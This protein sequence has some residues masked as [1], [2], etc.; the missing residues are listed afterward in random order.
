[1][2]SLVRSLTLLAL[3]TVSLFS[4]AC[5]VA[6]P[7][8]GS[9]YLTGTEKPSTLPWNQPQKWE[10]QGALGGLNN[11]SGGGGGGVFGNR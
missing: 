7:N 11:L 6:P 1:M 2:K 9:Q 3:A 5:A 10:G 8:D 4:G